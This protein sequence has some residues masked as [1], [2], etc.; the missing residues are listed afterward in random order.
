[1]KAIKILNIVSRSFPL[2]E[3]VQPILLFNTS[4]TFLLLA[5]LTYFIQNFHEVVIFFWPE[6][7][8]T[9][10]LFH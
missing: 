3:S 4:L 10:R 7:F 1:M 6:V 2:A 9:F 5:L 8:L